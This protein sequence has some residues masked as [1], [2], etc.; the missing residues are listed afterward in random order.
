[1][2]LF[3]FNRH[4]GITLHILVWFISVSNKFLYLFI[5]EPT[6]DW[7]YVIFLWCVRS[8]LTRPR[9]V[10]V[11]F[12][13]NVDINCFEWL[14]QEL[15]KVI[16]NSDNTKRKTPFRFWHMT[17]VFRRYSD[18]STSMKKI[19]DVIKTVWIFFW[20]IHLNSRNWDVRKFI[21]SYAIYCWNIKYILSQ[22]SESNYHW[23][24]PYLHVIMFL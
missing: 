20:V 5:Y 6:K 16:C 24:G 22:Y 8:L 7:S 15:Q 2:D 12:L 11:A 23:L 21:A 10:A 19:H 13:W 3:I 18:R 9:P 14:L 4:S 17:N 1:M